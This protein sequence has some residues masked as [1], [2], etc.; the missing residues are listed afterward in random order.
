MLIQKGYDYIFKGPCNVRK[1]KGKILIKGIEIEDQIN[2]DDYFSIVP[3]ED[4][5]IQTNC[6]PIDKIQHLGWEELILNI[7]NTQGTILLLGDTDSGKTYFSTIAK[8]LVN[9]VNIDADVGQSTYFLPTFIS[10]SNSYL[11]FFGSISPSTNFRLHAQLTTKMFEK[12]KSKITIIDTDGWITGFKAFQHK[13]ELIYCIDPDYIIT[14][15]E[16]IINFF[17]ENIK[18]KIILVK[19]APIFLEKN[20]IKRILYRKLKY[21]NYFKD[22]KEFKI[23]YEALFGKRIA[24]NLI[25]SWNETLQISPEEPCYGYYIYKEDLKG[26]LLGLTLHGKVIGAGFIK[27][28]NDEYIT[29]STPVDQFT[30]IIP[31]NIS[32]NDN[33]EDKKIKIQKC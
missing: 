32:L 11:E 30:G 7:S 19:R 13:L 25:L 24:E 23:E 12:I 1:I 21:V 8:N 16:K 15:N 3:I 5:E 29:I 26:L 17:P 22:S 4:S 27:N 9:S 31:S 28:I 14:F 10:S 2:L 33:F 20:R 18:K 6:Q